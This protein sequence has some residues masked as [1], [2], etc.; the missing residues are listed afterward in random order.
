VP[1]ALTLSLALRSFARSLPGDGFSA[2]PNVIL[3]C[4]RCDVPVHQECYNIDEIPQHEWLCWPCR[5]HEDDLTSQGKTREEIR[6]ASLSL[7]HRSQLP[8]GSKDAACALCP[9]KGGAFRKT[10]DGKQWVHQACAAW[11]PEVGLRKSNACAVVTNLD[12]IPEERLNNRCSI[13]D[14]TRGAVINCPKLGCSNK[15]HVVC[16]KRCGLYC[17]AGI[18]CLDHGA[19]E[20][21]KDSVLLAKRLAGVVPKVTKASQRKVKD[22]GR[23]KDLIVLQALEDELARMHALRVN[24]EQLRQLLDLSK[25]REKI[26]RAYMGACHDA[27][28][29]RMEHPEDALELVEKLGSYATA[30]EALTD[31]YG[32]STPLNP[33]VG[34]GL[35]TP[36]PDLR[37]TPGGGVAMAD[38]SAMY[39]LVDERVS[40]AG[41]PRRVAAT[42]ERERVM[43]VNEAEAIN[44]SLPPGVRYVRL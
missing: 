43:S 26:K 37:L 22:E 35:V 23:K 34:L 44:A 24:F 20:Q 38:G 31:L 4:D 6:P 19:A 8:G 2:P 13:C 17:A 12:K 7:E 5:E 14:Q 33:T 42:I 21:E 32:V 15:Y 39:A 28:K 16:A 30:T 9:I 27:F 1:R 40:K 36:N 29:E 3:F 25:R 18:F 11:H 41:R 10:V